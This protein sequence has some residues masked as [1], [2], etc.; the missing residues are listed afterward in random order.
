MQDID[1]QAIVVNGKTY[2]NLL[3]V[4]KAFGVRRSDLRHLL[5]INM[6]ADDAI[7]YLVKKVE[8]SKPET[9]TK[10][11]LKRLRKEP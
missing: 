5:R 1:K 8:A 7:D 6:E 9:T 4:A 2:K 10:L 3:A 11:L